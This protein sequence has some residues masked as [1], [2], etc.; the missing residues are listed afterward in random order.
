MRL[1]VV[2]SRITFAR[3]FAL[4]ALPGVQPAGSYSIET[5]NSYFWAFP[6]SWRKVTKVTIR[7]HQNS[8]LQGNLHEVEI[9]S[10]DLSQCVAQRQ[11]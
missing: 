6:W 2:C 11:A 3:P 4:N 9:G 10:A 7:L 5:N 8:G 1:P